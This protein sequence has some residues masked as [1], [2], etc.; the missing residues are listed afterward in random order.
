MANLS[1]THKVG[2]KLIWTGG[3][4]SLQCGPAQPGSP[5]VWR[6]G[7]S[8]L[9]RVCGMILMEPKL[10]AYLEQCMGYYANILLNSP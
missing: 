5:W 1:Y 4:V 7:Q 10:G 2:D 6:K 9:A 8:S 3:R